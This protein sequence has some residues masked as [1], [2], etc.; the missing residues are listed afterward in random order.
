[1]VGHVVGISDDEIVVLREP[2]T[3]PRLTL[4]WLDLAEVRLAVPAPPSS[5]ETGG[6][7]EALVS[8][9]LVCRLRL[10]LPLGE[11][12]AAPLTLG[13]GGQQPGPRVGYYSGGVQEPGAD[14]EVELWIRLDALALAPLLAAAPPAGETG[15][16]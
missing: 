12:G 8:R 16:A 6:D 2:R 3:L 13:I 15:H 4:R 5:G 7:D 10:R 9:E 11:N 14:G 1:V